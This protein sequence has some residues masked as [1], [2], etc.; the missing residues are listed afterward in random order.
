MFQMFKRSKKVEN[1]EVKQTPKRQKRAFVGAFNSLNNRFNASFEKINGELRNDYIALTLRAR[2]LAKNNEV[3]Q[4]YINLM[5]R[6]VLGANGFTLNCTSYNEDGTSDI[7]ANQQIQD[8]WHEYQK[9]YKNYVSADEQSNGLDFDRQI[10]FNYLVDGEVFI[11]K[12]KDTKSKFGIRFEIIDALDVDSLY[13][14]QNL[15]GGYRICMGIKVD[16]HCK[17]ISYFIRKNKSL[18]YYFAGERV[19]VQADEIIHIYKKNFASQVRGYTP[20]AAVLLSLNSLDEYKKAEINAAVL[21]ANWFG[22]WESQSAAADAYQQFNEDEIDENGDI[23]VQIESNVI[24]YAPKNYKLNAVT[25]NHPNNNVDAFS[26]AICKGIA[27]ALGMSYNKLLSDYESTSYSSLRQAN[28]QDETTAKELQQFIIDKWKNKQYAQFLK[29]LLLSDLTN[30]PFAKIDK[31]MQHNFVG[32]N[33][34]Y[35]DPERE[36]KAI[37][38]RLSLG[39]SSPIEEI[40]NLGKDPFDVLDSWQKWNEMLKNRGLKLSD[41]MNTIQSVDNQDDVKKEDIIQEEI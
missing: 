28:M 31:F 33:F 27:G 3:V 26:K 16:A 15:D 40:H 4:S 9:S 39:L 2:A 22:V 1:K 12:V 7:V 14:F 21:N 29:Y 20:L 13:S 10:L 24:R 25:S 18:D 6:S 41:T 37:E 36:M 17:P 5:I 38:L 11:H 23:P 30:L 32:K 35:L 19:E 34:E 8:F